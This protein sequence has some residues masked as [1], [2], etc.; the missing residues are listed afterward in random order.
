MSKT[1]GEVAMDGWA[2][3][4]DDVSSLEAMWESAAQAVAA[5]VRQQCKEAINA[6]ADSLTHDRDNH[7]K[8]YALQYI[9]AIDQLGDE[10]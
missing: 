2:L 7:A 1:L 8:F 9:A 3:A 5:V 6:S 4:D 10:S